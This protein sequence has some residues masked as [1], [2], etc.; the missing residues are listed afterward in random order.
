MPAKSKRNRTR[1]SARKP[2]AK[3][4]PVVKPAVASAPSK[5]LSFDVF[6]RW[7][8]ALQFT[9]QIDCTSGEWPSIKLGLAVKWAVKNGASLVGARL[10]G[11]SL[12]G[13]SLVGASLD[14]A[15][16]VGASLVGARL[17]GARLVGA[18]LNGASLVGARLDG[19]S[20]VGASLDGARLD[21][22]LATKDSLFPL[23]WLNGWYAYTFFSKEHGH[24]VRVGCRDV[25]IEEGRRYWAGKPDRREVLAGLDFAEAIGRLRGWIAA[26]VDSAAWTGREAAE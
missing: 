11:A 3:R 23:G 4:H 8:G 13:A 22:T 19:A 10:D 1:K 16:L 15:S 20:L 18:S 21:H 7:S 26:P 17:D 6:N 2:A 9:A 14:G 5:L 24:R 25:S 12:N